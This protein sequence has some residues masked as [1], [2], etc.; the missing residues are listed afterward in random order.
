MKLQLLQITGKNTTDIYPLTHLLT[1]QLDT[2]LIN[3][4]IKWQTTMAWGGELKIKKYNGSFIQYQGIKHNGTAIRVFWGNWMSD[5]LNNESLEIL[6]EIARKAQK[7][8]YD[9]KKCVDEAAELLCIMA[10]RVYDKMADVD[11]LLQGDGISRGKLRD[12]SGYKAIFK[13][14]ITSH[15]KI[16][17]DQFSSQAPKGNSDIHQQPLFE[18]KPGI[19]GF[20]INLIE[21]YKRLCRRFKRD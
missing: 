10:S 2:K 18:A 5:Y 7:A 8:N 16:S 14:Y 15:A 19:C 21:A 3:L 12:V 13:N 17:V 4:I 9:V 20:K 11:S 1:K 6:N